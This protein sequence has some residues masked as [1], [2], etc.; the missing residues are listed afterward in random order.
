VASLLFPDNTVLINFAIINRMDLLSRV[1][2]GQGRWCATVAAECAA[3]SRQPELSALT[4]APDILGDALYP[5][6]GAEHSDVQMMRMELAEPGDSTWQHLGEAE[7]L[8]IM[9]RRSLGGYFVTDDTGAGRLGRKY[10]VQV[11]STWDLLRLAARCRFV[12]P[13][14]LWGYLGLLRAAN[15]GGPPSVTDRTSIDAWLDLPTAGC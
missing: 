1:L 15:R 11:A 14:T 4:Q 6:T 7:T 9:T 3:S 8:A 12:D 10:G 13:D 2:N 5:E